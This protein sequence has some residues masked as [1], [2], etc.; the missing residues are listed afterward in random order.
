MSHFRFWLQKWR[1][2]NALLHWCSQCRYD[3][4]TS[5]DIGPMWF[6]DVAEAGTAVNALDF[7]SS[8]LV[9][10]SSIIAAVRTFTF[11]L[12]W[13]LKKQ[14]GKASSLDIAPLTILNSGTFTTS[15]VAAD[16]QWTWYR[17]ARSG[18]PEPALTG[19]WA[20]SCSQ[21]AYYAP[22]NHARSSPRNP[23]GKS[24]QNDICSFRAMTVALTVSFKLI[25]F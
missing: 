21:Q 19:Y 23:R 8:R 13:D 6:Q 2:K 12:S 11:V 4:D 16:W 9:T 14:K 3:I 20:H 10:C 24:W 7:W 5:S 15:E 1:P 25:S 18:S 17:G 22:V